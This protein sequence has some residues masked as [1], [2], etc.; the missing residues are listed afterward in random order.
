M[1]LLVGKFR[2]LNYISSNTILCSNTLFFWIIC[3]F[4]FRFCYSEM[5]LNILYAPNLVFVFCSVFVSC[6]LFFFSGSCSNGLQFGFLT[7][8]ISHP[9]SSTLTACTMKWC[10]DFSYHA[11][12]YQSNFPSVF[13]VHL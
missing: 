1:L 6:L 8:Q 13:S 7:K 11:P 3:D 4:H 9:I 5:S 2:Q 10:T 12:R